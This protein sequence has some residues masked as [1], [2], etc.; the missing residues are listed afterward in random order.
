MSSDH[1]HGAKRLAHQRAKSRDATEY[2]DTGEI[3]E[4]IIR[5]PPAENGGEEAVGVTS[6]D[7][8][9]DVMV[10]IDPGTEPLHRGDRVRCRIDH[11]AE[12]Y[13]KAVCIWKLS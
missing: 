8:A 1:H 5:E 7:D 12:S 2:F 11:V 13:L 4:L 3:L 10:F 9:R 6:K